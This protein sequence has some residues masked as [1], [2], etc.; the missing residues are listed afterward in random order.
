MGCVGEMF[1]GKDEE[2]SGETRAKGLLDGVKQKAP[3][4]STVRVDL[5]P[6]IEREKRT[7]IIDRH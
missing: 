4:V 5:R 6:R 1:H 3:Q 7:F 2:P